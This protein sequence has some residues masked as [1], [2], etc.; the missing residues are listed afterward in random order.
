MKNASDNVHGVFGTPA[1]PR[2]HQRRS[3][4]PQP[5][6]QPSP[7]ALEPAQRQTAIYTRLEENIRDMYQR[8]FAGVVVDRSRVR[9][10]PILERKQQREQVVE[11]EYSSVNR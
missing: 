9:A 1:V 11:Q 6:A 10:K 3:P 7:R 4:P 5:R 2:P 8:A